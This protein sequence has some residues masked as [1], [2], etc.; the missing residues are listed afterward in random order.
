MGPFTASQNRT[1][2]VSVS[3]C[4]RSRCIILM[5]FYGLFKRVHCVTKNCPFCGVHEEAYLEASMRKCKGEYQRRR[6]QA[7][8]SWRSVNSI[9]HAI[10]PTNDKRA[11]PDKPHMV[12]FQTTTPH[13]P[14]Q[15]QQFTDHVPK[16]RNTGGQHH[17]SR[18]H[19]PI[20]SQC[21]ARC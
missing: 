5:R 18:V 17:G 12:P 8:G 9:P 3:R 20:P 15:S 11:F 4:P 2:S 19:S 1:N 7:A 6:S 16:S 14:Q 10:P 13:P 21:L